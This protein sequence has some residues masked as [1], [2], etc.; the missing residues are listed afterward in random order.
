MENQEPEKK[1]HVKLV[2]AL[3]FAML[4]ILPLGSIY[5]LSSGTKYRKASHAELKDHGKVGHFILN[6]QNNISISPEALHG[7][8]TVINFLSDDMEVAK[9]QTERIA[10]VHQSYNNVEDVVFLSFIKSDST[11]SM[12]DRA[13][14]LGILDHDQWFLM[15]T[16]ES[17]W[18][19][20][21]TNAFQLPNIETGVA[22]VDTSLTIRRYYNITSNPEM[23]RLVEQIAIVIPKQ[24]RRGM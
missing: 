5:F 4:F 3:I 20:I 2:A 13:Q 8:V 15:G 23:G 10:K 16:D 21:A 22:L 19:G 18:T 6:N 11:Q 17:E 9:Q 1:K 7:R 24:T 14:D 12:L